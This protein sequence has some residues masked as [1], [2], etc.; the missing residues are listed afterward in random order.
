MGE[1]PCGRAARKYVR[2]RRVEAMSP[3]HFRSDR[4]VRGARRKLVWATTDQSVTLGV[5]NS[6][7]VDLLAGLEVAGSSILGCTIMRT[8]C[9]LSLTTAITLGDRLRVGFVVGRAAEVGAGVVGALTAA[10]PE[11]DW[12]LWRHETAA[13]TFGTES[14]NNQLVYDIKAKRKMQELSQAYILALGNSVG[15]SKTMTIQAR[16]LIALP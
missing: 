16:T 4:Q 5:G 15:A 8:H 6:S 12:L 13:P 1:T 10:T 14:N 3:R 9:E 2:N 7:N 11:L